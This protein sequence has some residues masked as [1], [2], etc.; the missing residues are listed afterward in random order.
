M[1]AT[2]YAYDSAYKSTF[3]LTAS[4][5]HICSIHTFTDGSDRPMAGSNVDSFAVIV[6]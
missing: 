2:V 6:E 5:L 4:E 1:N 3:F